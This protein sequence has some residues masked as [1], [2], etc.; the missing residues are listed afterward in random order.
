MGLTSILNR[1]A[2]TK[3]YYFPPAIENKD[4]QPLVWNAS[5]DHKFTEYTFAHHDFINTA[6]RE[7]GVAD[8]N[9]WFVRVKLPMKGALPSCTVFFKEFDIYYTATASGNNVKRMELASPISRF[10]IST[11]RF[12]IALCDA[13]LGHDSMNI[14]DNPT[15]NVSHT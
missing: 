5:N 7:N 12:G 15:E 1:V 13:F 9:K 4:L 6:M 10:S 2:E 11:S 14:F 3:G 8:G